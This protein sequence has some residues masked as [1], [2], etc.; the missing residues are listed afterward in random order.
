MVALTGLVASIAAADSINPSTVIPGLY[1]ARGRQ[2]GTLAW[3]IAGVFVVYLAGGLVLALGPGP[4][5]MAALRHVGPTVDHAAEAGGGVALLVVGIVTWRRRGRD[6]GAAARAPRP[7]GR[8]AGLA[9]GV[10]ISAV[11]LPTA[12]LY[13]GAISAVLGARVAVPERVA[14]VVAYNV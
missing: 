14:L 8:R 7:A 6:T 10:A 5:L 9:A 1:L 4:A 3:F 11:E 2:I 12:F 13:F